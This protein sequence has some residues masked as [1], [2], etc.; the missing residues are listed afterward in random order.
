M[1]DPTA[2]RLSPSG[3]V[4]AFARESLP[5]FE[6]WPV[7]VGLGA[8]G[9]PER[10]NAAVE[11]VD[12][13]I[14]AHGS[15]RPALIGID[16][17]WSYGELS[18]A[19]QQAANVLVDAG[20]VPGNRVLLRGPNNPLLAIA[21]LAVVRVGGVVVTTMPMLRA[22]ELEKISDIAR[23]Q[24]ALVDH[25]YLE[26]WEGVGS[27][28]GVTIPFGGPTDDDLVARCWVASAVNV[29]ADTAAD[30]VCLLAF[31]SGTTGKPKATMHFHRD[32]L[33][34]ADTFSAH[35]V[36][37]TCDDVFAGSPP[38]AFTFGLGAVVIFPL[39]AGASTV[40]LEAASPPAL[41]EA[42]PEYRITCLFTAPTAYRAMLPMATNADLSSLRRC[43]SAGETLPSATWQAWFDATGI[44]LIDGIGATELLHIFIS[45]SDHD[46]RPGTT[47]RPVP[48]FIAEV[49]DEN[50]MA[51]PAGVP[52][53]LAV[54]GPVGCRYLADDRQRV[55]VRGGWNITGDVYLMDEAGYFHYQSRADDM[56]VSSGYNIAAPEVEG[57]LLNHSAVAETAV[58]GIPDIDRGMLVKAF[59]VLQPGFAADPSMARGLQDHVKATIAPYKYPRQIEFVDEL[60]KTATGKLQR[61][62]LKEI[63]GTSD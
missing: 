44:K 3:H 59:V 54:R 24:F 12:S 30:D 45:A 4:D 42:I 36:K 55:Y 6:D 20:V 50:L 46:I 60:P 38:I 14:A 22:V 27:F 33:A 40:L 21:W 5:P 56:I 62:R 28:D 9:Y 32:V 49:V 35:I 7:L 41:L 43:V 1:T 63:T 61:F 48:G 58:I 31:T 10:L 57:A 39:R 51:L 37:P 15:D 52:G 13:T 34:I 18:K 19:V 23:V 17:R 47:G 29:A 8:L 11:L 16:Q 2:Q 26:E 53:L 25:R